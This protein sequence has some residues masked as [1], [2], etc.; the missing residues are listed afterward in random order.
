MST[1]FTNH[2]FKELRLE[3]DLTQEVYGHLLGFGSPQQRV[4]E[5]ENGV[6]RVSRMVATQCRNI[7]NILATGIPKNKLIETMLTGQE[8]R[9]INRTKKGIAIK[10]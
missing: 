8:T 4:S 7:K 2:D 3:L 5:I 6:E 1:E 10:R 9:R